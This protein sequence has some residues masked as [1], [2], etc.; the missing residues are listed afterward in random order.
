M[1]PTIISSTVSST[2]RGNLVVIL[3]TFMTCH[4]S[5]V[6]LPLFKERMGG[7]SKLVQG[8]PRG[9]VKGELMVYAL[10]PQIECRAVSPSSSSCKDRLD[11]NLLVMEVNC[12]NSSETKSI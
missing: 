7:S 10:N 6:L 1:M 8:A 12:K 5:A 11:R 4:P 2:G 3:A 9:E